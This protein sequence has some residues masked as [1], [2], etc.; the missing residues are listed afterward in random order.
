[1]TTP[2][3]NDH[4]TWAS[5]PWTP[6]PGP[7]TAPIGWHKH[8]P[9]LAPTRGGTAL[10]TLDIWLP[11]LL[12]TTS[13]L[14]SGPGTWLI[15]IHGGAWR[16]PAVTAASFTAAASR[17]LQR[18]ATAAAGPT[19][20]AGIASLNYRLSP[21]PGH[22]APGDPA[23][24]A[25]HPDHIAD[26]L[27][28]LAFLQRAGAAR[29]RYV[30][31]GHS[32]GATLA[33][34]AVMHPRRWGVE[35]EVGKPAVVVGFNG[36]YDLAGFIRAPPEGWEGLVGPYEEFI[37]GAFG[38]EEAV[39]RAVCPATAEGVVLVQSRED[40]L[41]PSSQLESMRVYLEGWVGEVRTEVVEV[42]DAGD[43][44]DMWGRGDKMAEVLWDV[45]L[46]V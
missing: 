14:P 12:T 7:N 8:L 10:H 46:G 17:L 26:V 6:I 45:L 23:R 28:G 19:P 11:S 27:A 16:D 30:L 1:M 38:P 44:D 20:L 36:L 32:C 39:W 29:G 43:H 42:E 25:A 4:L 35:A 15:Y 37:R 40:T 9:Y 18:A 33:L 3:D 13:T 21:H 31:V 2:A 24:A 5:A 34:Q 22:P 41:V